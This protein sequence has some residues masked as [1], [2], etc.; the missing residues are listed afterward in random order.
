[1]QLTFHKINNNLQKYQIQERAQN[2]LKKTKD[3]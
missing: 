1:M 3:T 2:R